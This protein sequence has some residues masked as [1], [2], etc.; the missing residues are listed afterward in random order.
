[1]LRSTSRRMPVLGFAVAALMALPILKAEEPK[2][3]Y[4]TTSDGVKIHYITMGDHG[5]WVVLIH[6]FSDSAQRMFFTTGIAPA[7]AKNH[8]VVAIDNR[9]HG[10]SDKPNPNGS[11]RAEDTIELMDHLQIA[12]A[13]IHGYSMGGGFTGALLASHP[14]R[15]ITAIFGG[16]GIQEVDED[17]RKKAAAMDTPMPTPQGAEAAAFQRLRERSA[18]AAAA[19]GNT[20]APTAASTASASPSTT[21]TTP[22]GRPVAVLQIDLTKVTIPVLAIN[23]EFDSPHTKTQR[24]SRELKNFSNVILPAKNHV[25]AIAVGGPMPQQYIDSLVDFIDANDAAMAKAGA[26][27]GGN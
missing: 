23:G 8:R 15:F 18:A 3:D 17:L 13:H 21:T 19:R 25:G 26:A 22:A 4:F 16:S 9:N 2:N 1:M 5:S 20:T 7:L 11:G 6:G 14:E 12:K 27:S 24:M 10:L